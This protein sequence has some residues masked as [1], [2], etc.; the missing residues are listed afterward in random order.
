MVKYTTKDALKE[1]VPE[2]IWSEIPAPPDYD[3]AFTFEYKYEEVNGIVKCV[4]GNINKCFD[5][6]LIVNKNKEGGKFKGNYTDRLS[7]SPAEAVEQ[8]FIAYSTDIIHARKTEDRTPRKIKKIID[9]FRQ[10]KNH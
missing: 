7:N 9:L 1:R 2:L 8:A 6:K 3:K 5:V 4:I 10:R